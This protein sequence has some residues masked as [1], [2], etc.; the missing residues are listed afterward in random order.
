MALIQSDNSRQIDVLGDTPQ[1]LTDT[2][3]DIGTEINTRGYNKMLV[4]VNIDIGDSTNVQLRALAKTT[5]DAGVLEWEYP[6]YTVGTTDVGVEG[7]YY[8]WTTDE[9]QLT[10]LEVSLKGLI[11]IIQL[12]V[13]AAA[14]QTTGTIDNLFVHL[15]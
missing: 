8:E 7:S 5:L 14:N 12:Q 6:I 3:V 11:P 9:D 4:W 2:F 10:I 1:A 15:I 13:K